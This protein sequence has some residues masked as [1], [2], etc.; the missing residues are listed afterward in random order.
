M[1]KTKIRRKSLSNKKRRSNKKK[2]VRRQKKVGGKVVYAE[3][4][5]EGTG[6]L[7]DNI[8]K[9]VQYNSKTGEEVVIPAKTILKKKT[10]ER[11]NLL[12]SINWHNGLRVTE[13]C[14]PDHEGKNCVKEDC[15]PSTKDCGC[16]PTENEEKNV[17]L[18]YGKSVNSRGQDVTGK[19]YPY[20]VR[21]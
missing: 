14:K 5:A 7:N 2:S 18:K 20:P 11:T 12:A 4:S 8:D 13:G 10:E 6:L 21:I 17:K 15:N 1:A 19:V 3:N 9:C 16:I